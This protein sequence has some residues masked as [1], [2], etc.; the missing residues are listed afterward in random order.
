MPFFRFIGWQEDS[1]NVLAL[2]IGPCVT[3]PMHGSIQQSFGQSYAQ[4]CCLPPTELSFLSTCLMSPS[5]ILLCFV[6]V[7]Y[8][9]S[10][11]ALFT[12]EPF[13]SVAAMSARFSVYLVNHSYLTVSHSTNVAACRPLDCICWRLKLFRQTHCP[14]DDSLVGPLFFG[15][16][17]SGSAWWAELRAAACCRGCGAG[18]SVAPAVVEVDLPA[19]A[20][21]GGGG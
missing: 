1:Y 19:R 20:L 10:T 6:N 16:L 18:G 12:C 11:I 7:A 21:Q 3:R 9:F 5:D 13:T 4:I 2:L 14:A 8:H 15:V 17:L